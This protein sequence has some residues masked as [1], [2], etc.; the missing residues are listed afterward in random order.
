MRDIE[1]MRKKILILLLCIC[2]AVL[3]FVLDPESNFFPKCIFR[4]I[5]GYSCPGCGSQRAIHDLL[6]LDLAGAFRHNAFLV[7]SIPLVLGLIFLERRKST[8]KKIHALFNSPVFIVLLISLVIVW[9]I[10]RNVFHI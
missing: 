5:T 8:N 2:G 3:F 4:S 7:C 1:I 10:L 9:W 6:H